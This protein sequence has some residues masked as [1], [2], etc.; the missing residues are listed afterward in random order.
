[1]IKEQTADIH[2]KRHLKRK[3]FKALKKHQA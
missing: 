1:M 3:A 2:R